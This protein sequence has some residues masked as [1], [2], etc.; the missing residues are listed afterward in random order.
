[1]TERLA[2][3]VVGDDAFAHRGEQPL[4]RFADQHEIDAVRVGADDR[5]RHARH[6]P[7]RAHA[8]IEVEDEAQFDLR[9]DLGAVGI[10][11]VGQAAGAEQNGVGIAAELY[12]TLRHRLAG[13]AIMPGAGRRFA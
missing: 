2:R 9:H 8:G 7:G 5:A 10:A 1:M 6:Q 11:H 12:G 13:V 3:L 4:R